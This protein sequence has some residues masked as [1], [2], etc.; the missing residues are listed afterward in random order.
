MSA[1]TARLAEGGP[2]VTVHDPGGSPGE[3]GTALA[4]CAM[5]AS[6]LTSVICDTEGTVVVGTVVAGAVLVVVA[7]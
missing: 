7:G 4:C 3:G 2:H 5:A 1:P 6:R